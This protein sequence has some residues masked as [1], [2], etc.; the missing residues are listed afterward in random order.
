MST[1]YRLYIDDSGN[2]DSKTNN[3][4]ELRYGSLTGVLFQG[5]Y[6]EHRFNS[7][8]VQLSKKHFGQRENDRPHNLHRRLL[9]TKAPVDKPFSV[10]ADPAA[11]KAWDADALDMFTRSKYT[12][13]TACVDKIAWY[14]KYPRWNGDF[15]HIL[16]EGI[17]SRSYY[18]L[19][20][21]DAVA[22]VNVETK[23]D[24]DQRLKEEY[25]R[26]L[27]DGY[28]HITGP[29]LQSVFT[30]KEI[31]ILN[32]DCDKPGIQ[33]ADLLASPA[34]RHIRFDNTKLHPITGDFTQ[35]LCK[36]LVDQ[37]FYREKTSPKGHGMI[38]RP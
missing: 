13:I 15:Y 35:N 9:A 27:K 32:K 6:L 21:R 36:V 38:W 11:R 16:V 26:T 4:P 12:V 30:S 22:E 33:M 1:L 5:D 20:K 25:K 18:F 8:F 7:S 19:H 29:R 37:K 17:L 28:F 24:R 10:L 31:N 23:G 3:T 34:F 2:V 14:Y